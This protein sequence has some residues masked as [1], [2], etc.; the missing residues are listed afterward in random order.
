MLRFFESSASRRVRGLS[1]S[2]ALLAA[3]CSPLAHADCR[4]TAEPGTI[5]LPLSPVHIAVPLNAPVGTQ[6]GSAHAAIVS[7][8][9]F[10]CSGPDNTRELRVLAP[11]DTNS[12]LGNVYA[13]S[14]PG[15]GFRIITRGGSFAGID[16]GPRDAAYRVKLPPDAARLTGFAVDIAFVT[17]GKTQ[18]GA[19][20][21]GKLASL[22]L[23]GNE[24]IDVTVPENGVVFDAMQCTPVSVSGEMSAGVGTMGSF[25]QEAAVISTG[26]GAFGASVAIGV[27]QG[28][29]YG[30]HPS[31]SVDAAPRHHAH[32]S[33]GF[34]AFDTAI[35]P[36]ASGVTVKRNRDSSGNLLMD[37]GQ[38]DTIDAA[39]TAQSSAN[40]AGFGAGGMSARM[41]H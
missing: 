4:P 16:D 28:Y 32:E 27:G 39:G 18:G 12:G 17:T 9:P 34:G 11:A 24:F 20:A 6:V 10:T 7:D 2:L 26:C 21:P 8:I 41:R 36:V 19:L 15:I 22:Y 14:L 23:G 1:L 29:I 5:V 35:R 3:C 31:L 13:T 38:S 25:T 40:G 37:D 33:G 30:S